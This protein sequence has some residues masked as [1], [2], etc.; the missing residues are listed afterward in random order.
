MDHRMH[1]GHRIGLNSLG[2][3]GLSMGILMGLSLGINMGHIMGIL[4][5]LSLGLSMGNNQ[6]LGLSLIP[7]LGMDLP[8]QV[9]IK[10]IKDNLVTLLLLLDHKIG[11]LMGHLPLHQLP[12]GYLDKHLA[13]ML[14]GLLHREVLPLLRP[15]PTKEDKLFSLVLVQATAL[16][17]M[18]QAGF[19]TLELPIML[20]MTLH[21]LLTH[22]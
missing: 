3:M 18:S 12:K 19:Q 4:T 15:P 22:Y 1:L 9:L 11:P 8:D 10:A 16:Q 6:H 2:L 20:P 21:S 7:S 13:L 17:V 14:A 5:G